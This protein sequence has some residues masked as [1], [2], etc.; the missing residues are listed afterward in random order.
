MKL[1][2]S[3]EASK[4]SEVGVKAEKRLEDCVL[5]DLSGLKELG[6]G[7]PED[8]LANTTLPSS[9]F[10]ASY[11]QRVSSAQ[12]SWQQ[13]LS[14]LPT[15]EEIEAQLVALRDLTEKRPLMLTS[16]LL[17]V[18]G[19]LRIKGE[20]LEG[21]VLMGILDPQVEVGSEAGILADVF[22]DMGAFDVTLS[23]SG[24]LD[25]PVLGLTSSAT[26][27]LSAAVQNILR[28][29]LKGTQQALK[30]AISANV[31]RELLA[32]N[33][34]TDTLESRILG[35]LSGRLDLAGMVSP[36]PQEKKEPLKRLKEGILGF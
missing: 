17:D 14:S 9:V 1:P 33:E 13:R 34:E 10:L 26:K 3:S 11:R 30:K 24:T 4:P 16:A 20:D 35:E 25:E 23:I 12:Q 29:Q 2:V 15:Q 8:L 5:P 27:K 19:S 7:V 28:T 21:Q 36:G 32:A 31:D 22:K 18:N 6:K